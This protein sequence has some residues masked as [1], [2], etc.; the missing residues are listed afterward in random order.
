M[1]TDNCPVTVTQSPVAGTLVGLGQT[2]VTLT[3]KDSSNNAVTCT[4]KV[5]V[6]DTTNPVLVQC[7]TDK[8][9][10]VCP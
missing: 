9:L 2:T 4:A 8:I 1:T 10:E 3:V 5:T 7:A 6:Q